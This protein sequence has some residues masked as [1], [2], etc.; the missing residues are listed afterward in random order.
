ME[1]IFNSTINLI[2]NK[3][4][5]SNMYNTI[6]EKINTINKINNYKNMNLLMNI[7]E[8]P[9][10]WK[11]I[12]DKLE[13]EYKNNEMYI[14]AVEMNKHY[15]KLINN[16]PMIYFKITTSSDY[17]KG[18]QYDLGL[19]VDKYKFKPHGCCSGGGL[20][21]CELKDLHNFLRYGTYL[22]PLIVP[23]NI[24]IYKEIHKED[25]HCGII[26]ENFN[27]YKAPCV[28]TLPRIKLNNEK[29]NKLISNSSP[30]NKI[31]EY[32]LLCKSNQ[33]FDLAKYIHFIEINSMEKMWKIEYL[34]CK[35]KYDY[36]LNKLILPNNIKIVTN[37]N[38][39]ISE[40]IIKKNIVCLDYMINIYYPH[41]VNKYNEK[42][43]KNILSDFN[44]EIINSSSNI[45][46]FLNLIPHQLKSIFEICKTSV[47]GS[48]VLKY[49]TNFKFRNNDIDIYININYIQIFMD[50]CKQNL[51]SYYR[52]FDV[53]EYSNNQYNM[54]NIKKI[55]TF[56]D[57][58][59][60]KYQIIVVDC[61]PDEF[62]KNNFDFDL[63]SISFNFE[64]NKF[65]NIVEKNNYNTLTIQKS[66]I[67]KII[68]D[69][70]D[71]YSTYR[72]YKTASRIIKYIKRGF[73]IDNWN[74]F[75]ILLKNNMEFT[76]TSIQ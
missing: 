7:Y 47:A 52:Q 62:I 50:Y 72:A 1:T 26:N 6:K 5:T 56:T 19:N 24:P 9:D 53:E 75:L 55:Y 20:Y 23:K 21:F 31:F 29:I 28:F 33:C 22:T 36:M 15:K 44:F 27:K 58:Y 40:I 51:Y 54:M 4:S 57:Y 46:N 74:M 45:N 76:K 65:V 8:N 37:F 68:G 38:R 66:Y 48:F 30:S 13:N 35:I 41:I 12:Y 16:E 67:N 42:Y 73:E 71:S 59:N 69:N 3:I 61:E 17:S 25:C 10:T 18:Y 43:S 32:L 49:I 70:K 2:L 39:I 60:K 11:L 34:I 63:C 64:K 14:E